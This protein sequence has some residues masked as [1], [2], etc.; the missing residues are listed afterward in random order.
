MPAPSLTQLVRRTLI[1]HITLLTD[2]GGIP[3]DIIRPVLLKLENPQQLK[4]LEDASPQL[5]GADE[6]IWISFIKRDIPD[7]EKKILYPKNPKSWWKVYRK[8]LGDHEKEVEDLAAEMKAKFSRIKVE[9]DQ[10]QI[11]RLEGIRK[12][13][14]L[15]GMEFAHAAEYNR[16]KKRPKDTRPTST[17]LSFRAGSKTKTLTGKGVMAK[18]QREAKEMSHFTGRNVLTIPTHKLKDAA[19]QVLVAPRHR[20]EELRQKPKPLDPTVPKP[21]MFVPP[22]RRV[23]RNVVQSKAPPGMMTTEERE[24]RLRAL[25][26]SSNAARVAT[27]PQP[28]TSSTLSSSATRPLVSTAA[29][30]AK[31]TSTIDKKVPQASTDLLSRGRKRSA[32]DPPIARSIEPTNVRPTNSETSSSPSP[33]RCRIPRL[34]PES[35]SRLPKKKAAVDPFIPVKRR[36]VPQ[37][38]ADLLSGGRKRSAED[39]S[40]ARSIESTN[41]QPASSESSSSPSPNRYR[42]PR[43]SP[44]SPSRLLKEKAAVDPFIP[45]KRRRLS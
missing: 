15:D 29:T 40:I 41:V 8:L 23:E 9:K 17:V 35:P 22:A 6:E 13:P 28:S 44:E 33:N 12:I 25:T 2:I 45:V 19:S 21:A 10:H 30:T 38:P 37:A 4:I 24:R 27:N 16:V 18:A 26:N 31:P 5:C 3:Y 36:Q 39:S 34:S 7:W 42:I 43:L 32:E 20:V 11:Q 1:K 14:K